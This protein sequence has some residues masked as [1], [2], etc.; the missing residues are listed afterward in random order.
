[1]G[2]KLTS[3]THFQ[4]PG[5]LGYCWKN[6]PSLSV[7]GEVGEAG[8]RLSHMCV[9]VAYVNSPAFVAC[10][11]QPNTP[12]SNF[13]F[14][15]ASKVGSFYAKAQLGYA[16]HFVQDSC[17]PFHAWGALL[18][19]HQEW[20]NDIQNQWL[21]HRKMISL[22]NDPDLL[23]DTFG[24]EVSKEVITA[25]TIEDLIQSNADWARNRFGT[26]HKLFEC[27]MT[28]MLAV[29]IRA[30]AATIKAIRLV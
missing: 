7:L 12:L 16:L 4:L 30:V 24:K 21:E 15:S 26:P 27:K 3:L 22:S 19:G 9:N 23:K 13:K 10:G 20:E 14:P 1:L 29:N 5:S 28:D 18:F 2:R 11:N 8:M 25:R 6:D 17:V